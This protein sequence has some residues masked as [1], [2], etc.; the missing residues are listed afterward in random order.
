MFMYLSGA[1]SAYTVSTGDRRIVLVGDLHKD[2]YICG[3]VGLNLPEQLK[4][5]FNELP[6]TKFDLFFESIHY[7]EYMGKFFNRN[8]PTYRGDENL[9]LWQMADH[10]GDC[11]YR[12]RQSHQTKR[13]PREGCNPNVWYHDINIRILTKYFRVTS[14]LKKFKYGYEYTMSGNAPFSRSIIDELKRAFDSNIKELNSIV[15]LI[16]CVIKKDVGGYMKIIREYYGKS[17]VWHELTGNV[18]VE[19]DLNK[20]FISNLRAYERRFGIE[21]TRGIIESI[22]LSLEFDPRVED[23]DVITEFVDRVN[24]FNGVSFATSSKELEFILNLISFTVS[25]PIMDVYSISRFEREYK[26]RDVIN[27]FP[28]IPSNIIIVAGGF[29]VEVYAKYLKLTYPDSDI[30]EYHL[31]DEGNP[32]RCILLDTPLDLFFQ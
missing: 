17:S 24:N 31:K 15:E 26:D 1:F 7:S 28:V 11:F 4:E 25:A 13:I 23:L 14:A 20:H 18:Y 12:Q 21:G 2:Y 8:I 19:Q 32:E 30:R 29:H 3:S 22:F 10:M 16:S 5:L 9:V 27:E 6:L